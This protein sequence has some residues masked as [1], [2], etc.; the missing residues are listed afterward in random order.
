VPGVARIRF[1][2]S[3]PKDLSDELIACFGE[4]EPLCQHLHLPVQSGSDAILSAMNRGYSRAHYLGLVDKL[5]RAC[6]DLRLTTDIIIGFPARARKISRRHDVAGE[7]A[8]RR[9][10]LVPL[11]AAPRHGRCRTA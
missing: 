4:L 11:L 6:P 8:L 2:T 5:R 1:T 10:L 3:H 9:D 7:G